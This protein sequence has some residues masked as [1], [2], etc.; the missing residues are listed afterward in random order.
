MGLEPEVAKHLANTYGDRAFSVAKLSALTGKR[1][2]VVGKRLH[3]EFPYIDAEVRYAVKEYAQTAVDIIAR[4][5]RIGF[6][7]AQAAVEALDT[8]VEIMGEELKWSAAEKK[9]RCIIS[10]CRELYINIFSFTI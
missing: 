5:T 7:N 4:R 2:P 10:Y 1:Y 8:V 3:T 9:V 6:L